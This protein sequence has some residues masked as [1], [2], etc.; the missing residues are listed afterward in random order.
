MVKILKIIVGRI[1]RRR[2][3]LW[4][5][6]I[7]Q[8]IFGLIFIG[9]LG[10]VVNGSLRTVATIKFPFSLIK[11]NYELSN[12]WVEY[13]FFVRNENFFELSSFQV[14]IS[15]DILYVNESSGLQERGR[16]Y[17]KTNIYYNIAPT[18]SL[19]YLINGTAENFNLRELQN[20]WSFADFNS[21]YVSMIHA[22]FQGG[23]LGGLLSF[24]LGVF[25]QNISKFE[26]QI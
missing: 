21:T 2:K 20:F 23:Y 24:Y 25:N 1:R 15:I 19:F 11:K 14:D 8:I 5:I 10:S 6:L 3:I 17:D 18:E 12:P 16:I 9:A 13:S 7:V 26:I 22:I 4:V